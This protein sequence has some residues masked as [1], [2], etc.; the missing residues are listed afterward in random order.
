MEYFPSILNLFLFAT[1][2][3]VVGLYMGQHFKNIKLG[4]TNSSKAMR[5]NYYVSISM[6]ALVVYLIIY[7]KEEFPNLYGN[8]IEFI[9]LKVLLVII[10]F[11][12]TFLLSYRYKR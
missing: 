11:A 8:T 2:S 5:L 9:I 1:V 12:L 7:T 6:L 3:G 10:I 4:K